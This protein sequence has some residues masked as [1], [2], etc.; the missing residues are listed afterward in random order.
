[1][2]TP[3]LS[4]IYQADKGEIFLGGK[5]VDIKK[6]L[7]A[8]NLGITMIHQEL[9]YLLMGLSNNN[10]E[11]NQIYNLGMFPFPDTKPKT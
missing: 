10:S 7:D 11:A 9:N 2:K 4:G 5:K 8:L 6:P 1:M 3:V